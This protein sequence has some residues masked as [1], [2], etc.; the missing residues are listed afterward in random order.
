MT[1]AAFPD[2]YNL[3]RS[4]TFRNNNAV[5][6]DIM[7]DGTPR[8]RVLGATQYKT[9]ACK[10]TYLTLADKDVLVTFLEDNASNTITWTIDGIDY[11][12]VF[13]DSYNLSMTGPLFNVDFTYYAA[14]V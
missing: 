6:T 5:Q 3:D 7:S 14:V 8:Q 2:G 4:T 12:G 1:T 13:I 10:I 11:S 9:I